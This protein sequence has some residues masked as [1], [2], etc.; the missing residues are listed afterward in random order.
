[1]LDGLFDI[2]RTARPTSRFG[3]RLGFHLHQPVQAG[4]GYNRASRAVH[5][6]LSVNFVTWIKPEGRRAW[7]SV[8]CSLRFEG[9]LLNQAYGEIYVK[10]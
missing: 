1:V 7:D 5:Q 6:N 3:N 4:S 2:V 8:P 10:E 9:M